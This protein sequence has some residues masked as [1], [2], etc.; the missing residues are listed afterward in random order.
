M[1]TANEI[2]AASVA[3]YSSDPRMK[4]RPWLEADSEV[5]D[6]Y[7][8]LASAGLVAAEK[9]RAGQRRIVDNS[10]RNTGYWR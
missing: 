5:Q 8:T 2:E 7:R 9:V 1:T 6:L 10:R 4:E 3:A